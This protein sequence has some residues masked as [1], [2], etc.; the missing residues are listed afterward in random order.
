MPSKPLQLMSVLRQSLLNEMISLLPQRGGYIVLEHLLP[1]EPVMGTFHGHVAAAVVIFDACL[2]QQFFKAHQS[3]IAIGVISVLHHQLIRISCS[4]INIGVL[5]LG[6]IFQ[7]RPCPGGGTA[8]EAIVGKLCGI[9]D[10]NFIGE[11][12][13]VRESGKGLTC[14]FRGN[15]VVLLHIR[16]QIVF[17]VIVAVKEIF[18]IAAVTFIILIRGE[19]I[20]VHGIIHAD[21]HKFTFS[22]EIVAEIESDS[23]KTKISFVIPYR[24][25]RS[26]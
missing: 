20:Y 2:I 4:Q 12:S 8:E 25:E 23:E 3:L 5:I 22:E 7:F 9:I 19:V 10:E 14:Y 13:A 16:H 26:H 1:G 17:D 15:I 21:N 18:I 24:E 6:I 11:F